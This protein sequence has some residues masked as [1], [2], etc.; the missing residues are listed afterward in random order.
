MGRW[1]RQARFL[2]DPDLP[3]GVYANI[4]AELALRAAAFATGALPSVV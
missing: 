3:G 1:L 4:E 2:W